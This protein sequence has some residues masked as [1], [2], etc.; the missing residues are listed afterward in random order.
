MSDQHEVPTCPSDGAACPSEGAACPE[1]PSRPLFSSGPCAKRPGWSPDALAGAVLGRS[2]RAGPGR[3]RLS[4]A[5]R[6]ARDVLQLPATHEIAIIPGSDTGA[7]ECALW[8]FIG[9]RGVRGVRGV[10]VLAFDA[11]GR[12]WLADVVDELKPLDI[13]RRSAPDGQLPDLSGLDFSR[14]TIFCWNGTTSGVRLPSGDFIADQRTGLTICDATSAAFAMP[15]PWDKLD[16]T[17]FSWQKALGGEAGLGM[18]V[19]SP[20]ARDRLLTSEP[21]RPLPKIFRLARAGRFIEGLFDG[22][23]LNTP[24][25]LCVEDFLDAL[26]WARSIGGLPSLI[27]RT[28]ANAAALDTWV[29]RTPWIAYLAEDPVIRSTTSVCLRLRDS[30]GSAE[31]ISRMTRLL[32]AEGAA[33]DIAAYRDAPPG[34]RI[35]CGPTVDSGDILRLGPWLDWAYAR[36]G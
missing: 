17:T 16:V 2:H 26:T 5:A 7:V 14:D 30:G 23:T 22:W 29:K 24:S 19:L 33:F 4:L 3:E 1:R 15:L 27:G 6:L 10:N 18:M 8:N 12:Q 9:A 31:R 11:F 35:W 13:E 34:L 28:A 36:S 20:N 21:P 32:E 25:L